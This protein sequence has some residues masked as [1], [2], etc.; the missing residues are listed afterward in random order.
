MLDAKRWERAQ[1][2]RRFVFKI[3]CLRLEDRKMKWNNWRT[4]T[5]LFC[6]MLCA[7]FAFGQAGNSAAQ[8]QSNR[9]AQSL[10]AGG[11]VDSA[12][13]TQDID[14]DQNGEVTL[15]EWGK[16]LKKQ[17]ENRN[18]QSNQAEMPQSK[19]LNDDSQAEVPN[20]ERGLAFAR[21]DVNANTL[22]EL[23]EWP[24]TER[25]FKRMDADRNGVISREEFMSPNG[26]FWHELFENLDF[27]RNGAISRSEWLDSENSFK[28]LDRSSDGIIDRWEFYNP[29]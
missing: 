24:G 12:Q 29:R 8:Q 18:T 3:C 19:S 5:I 16:Y 11:S 7:S 26:R 23:A 1:V 17:D 15:E 14:A 4:C 28:R 27:N 21:L 20:Y 6:L 2:R 10:A 13:L 22:V 9:G 25:P